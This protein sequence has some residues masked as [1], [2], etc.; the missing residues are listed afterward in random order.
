MKEYCLD[1][2]GLSNPLE[3]MPED[4]HASLWQE[5]C[6]LISSGKFA[7]TTEIFDEM[8]LLEGVVGKH[9]ESNGPELILEVGQEGWDWRTYAAHVERMQI[10]HK[11]FIS[12]YTGGSKK[13]IG[14]TDLSIVA[15]GRTLDLPVVS[16]EASVQDSPNKLRIP[17]LCKLEGVPHISFNDL[18]RQQ[19]IVI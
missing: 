19:K 13:T 4:I 18:L 15:L 9:I 17:D 3:N 6:E 12:E 8:K 10:D 14:L 16:M 1:T 11:D 7:V 2:S 5:V